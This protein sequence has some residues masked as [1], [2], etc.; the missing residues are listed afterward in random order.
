MNLSLVRPLVPRTG[1]WGFAALRQMWADG[2]CRFASHC[3]SSPD[4]ETSE[5]SPP[6]V[7]T[8]IVIAD[9]LVTLAALRPAGALATDAGALL[10]EML[11]FVETAIDPERR[12]VYFFED[13]HRLPPDVD[14]TALAY[15]TLARLGA[16]NAD[17]LKGAVDLLLRNMRNDAGVVEVY[18]RH[19]ADPSRHGILDPV[20]CC[21]ALTAAEA[22]N[23]SAD[24]RL[25][26]TRAFVLAHLQS[27]RYTDGT[28]YYMNG[29][30]FLY[31]AARLVYLFPGRYRQLG[32]ELASELRRL[33]GELLG[34]QRSPL[35]LAKVLLAR[36]LLGLPPSAAARDTARKLCVYEAN[37]L[38]RRAYGFFRYGRKSVYFGSG[39]LT[40]AFSLA[41]TLEE[42][43]DYQPQRNGHDQ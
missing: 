39:A 8:T 1:E 18:Y 27:G 4:F 32:R 24:A 6:E 40:L 30:S 9:L 20:V 21:N 34:A 31:F 33:D 29:A 10:C 7:F 2:G 41:A 3:S 25:D 38:V 12:V 35:A 14:C 11:Q 19:L 17:A 22:A 36:R 23:C 5:P 13:R 28:R 42:P 43:A 26:P 37:P 15:T 16:G